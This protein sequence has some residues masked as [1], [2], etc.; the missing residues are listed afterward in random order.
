MT[1]ENLLSRL[2]KVKKTSN[3]SWRSC[4]PS[5]NSTK[6]SLAIRD[7][8]GKVLVH[9]FAEGCSIMDILGA[10]GLTMDDIQPRLNSEHKPQKRPFYA[11]D[12]LQI[13]SN[14]T[15]IAYMIVKKMLDATVSK[16]D[17]ERLFTC[18]TR[19]RHA[20]DLAT[21]GY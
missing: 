9:C 19:L 21:K 5:H 11:N 14:E 6:Q 8:A 12:I 13:A 17:M 7:D 20:T 18:S 3:N 4:C 16:N 10:V 1:V 2:D 15:I